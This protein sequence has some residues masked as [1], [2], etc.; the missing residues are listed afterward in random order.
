MSKF[1]WKNIRGRPT[2]HDMVKKKI[3]HK[4]YRRNK[5]VDFKLNA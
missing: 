3:S 5:A 1:K 4:Q 2:R